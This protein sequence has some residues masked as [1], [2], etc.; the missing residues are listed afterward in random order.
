VKKNPKLAFLQ[1]GSKTA[2]PLSQL[3]GMLKIPAIYVEVAGKID[4]P[5][6]AHIPILHQKRSLMSLDVERLWR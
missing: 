1:R 2:C 4:L 6:L 3:C 5:F